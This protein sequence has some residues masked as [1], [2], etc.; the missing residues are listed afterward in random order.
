MLFSDFINDLV[1]GIECTVSML[2]AL[3]KEELWT[4]SGAEK[5][6]RE[7]WIESLAITNPMKCN[8]SKSWIIHLREGNPGCAHKLQ[9]NRLES[10]LM[11]T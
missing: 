10:S 6:Y 9:V 2:I 5:T 1:A 7:I 11:E 4:P 8:E 3:K